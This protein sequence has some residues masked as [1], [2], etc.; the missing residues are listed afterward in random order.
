MADEPPAAV[1]EWL[2]AAREGSQ[3]ALGQV[4]EAC[5]F[6]MLRVAEQEIDPGL[7]AKGGA[8]DIV[9]QTFL[10]AHRDF[11]RF[12]GVSEEEL[13]AW[14]RRLLLNN[15][16]DFRRH[17]RGTEKRAANRELSI[18]QGRSSRDWRDAFVAGGSTPSTEFRQQEELQ[19]IQQAMARL[20]EDYRMVLQYRY[21]DG[22]SFE[23]A[24]ARMDRSSAAT[25]KLFGR[26]IEL[27]QR[28]VDDAT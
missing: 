2:R 5:R 10:E 1:P 17:F 14:L 8:S 22:M 27:L 23:E 24:A 13:R 16:A 3:E 4:L 18:E 20:P 25:R 6:Y 11:P 26:A 19:A 28:L 12:Q 21:F 9:Q 15:V 7:R